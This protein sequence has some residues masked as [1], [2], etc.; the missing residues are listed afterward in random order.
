MPRNMEFKKDG[1]Y[2]LHLSESTTDLVQLGFENGKLLQCDHCVGQ[3][4]ISGQIF[5]IDSYRSYSTDGV[6]VHLS[7]LSLFK[8]L[9]RD[10]ML[11][12]TLGVD[13]GGNLSTANLAG[14]THLL[15]AGKEVL[16][17]EGPLNFTTNILMCGVLG[18]DTVLTSV[19]GKQVPYM[20]GMRISFDAQ[21]KV[22]RV[23]LPPVFP[24]S[25]TPKRD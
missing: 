13:D 2:D 9:G 16:F 6:M 3:A 20:K 7:H 23:G 15:V 24:P 21:G 14:P 1:Q 25:P 17:G 10:L 4:T 12:D 18:E 5:D 22:N 8:Y 19:D 11:Q